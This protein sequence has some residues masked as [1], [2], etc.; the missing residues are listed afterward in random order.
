MRKINASC[1]IL[2]FTSTTNKTEYFSSDQE[3]REESKPAI[4]MLNKV[5]KAANKKL[6]FSS[7]LHHKLLLC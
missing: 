4:I 3:P 6:V 5:T 2:C 7:E 1:S